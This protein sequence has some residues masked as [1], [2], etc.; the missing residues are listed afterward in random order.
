MTARTPAG[1]EMEFLFADRFDELYGMRRGLTDGKWKYIRNFNPHLPQ[2]PYS[3]YQFGQ[4]GWTAYEKAWKEGKVTG[5]HK[6][7]WE[8]PKQ[9]E[10]L[11][12]L[13]ADPWETR[14]L[15]ADPAHAKKLATLRS[16]LKNTMKQ[17]GDT[18]LIPEPLFDELSE[19]STIAEFAGSE[20]FDSDGVLD[21]AFTASAMDSENIPALTA[22]LS[23][24][25][26]VKRYW[27]TLGLLVIGEKSASSA[28]AVKPLLKDPTAVVRTTAAEALFRWGE[29]EAAAESMLNDVSV[30]MD[31]S[32]LLNLLNTIRR[33]DLLDRLP[34]G[35]AKE[36]N[37]KGGD[38]DYIKRF[39][40][41]AMD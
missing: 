7:Q 10:Q 39:S 3:F 23:S 37:M 14:N 4:P 25:D 13:T 38:Y 6:E 18:G 2:S 40:E 20:K 34:K 19:G 12:D 26:P 15:A 28:D 33:Y 41:R 24:E 9:S 17:A 8:A 29:K 21:L 32:S 30:K 27:G 31:P 5:I 11:Y 22:S 35:W 16:R 36:K 1:D